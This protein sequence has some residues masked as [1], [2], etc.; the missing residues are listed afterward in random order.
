MKT[1]ITFLLALVMPLAVW[2]TDRPTYRYSTI[3]FPGAAN[4]A[5][6]AINNQRQ[7]VGAM[8]ATTGEHRA[9]VG[10]GSQVVLLDPAGPLGTGRQSWAF[11]INDA[12][13]IAGVFIDAAGVNHGYVR[14]TSGA[15]EVID[16]PGASGTQAFGVNSRGSVIGIY[17]DVDGNLHAFTL[18]HGVFQPADLPGALQ[19][20]PFS[21]N[22]TEEIA[23][24]YVKT[25]DTLGFGYL[26][27]RDGRFTLTTAPGS[28]PEST[29][30]IS[31]NNRDEV[32]GAY[33]DAAGNFFNFIRI[34]ADYVPFDLP[35]S[36]GAVFVSAQTLND[37]DDIVGYYFDGNGV[38]H[39]FVARAER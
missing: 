31:I 19:T 22:D 32:L 5:L 37:H 39:G 11:S 28:A 12:G 33:A 1:L 30:F 20:Y 24:E 15:L 16:F 7:F 29:Y 25:A 34:G 38:A 35:A 9:I 17:F 18:R 10:T 13:D 2:A 23:G 3:D 4:T 21:I 36:F 27:D 14:R 6:Y 8:K 26:Q